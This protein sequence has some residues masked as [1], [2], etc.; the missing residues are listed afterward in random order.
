MQFLYF[1]HSS[2][3]PLIPFLSFLGGFQVRKHVAEPLEASPLGVSEYVRKE[4]EIPKLRVKLLVK[5]VDV[6]IYMIGFRD[7]CGPNL[8]YL[9]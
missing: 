4:I 7:A 6:R 1:S 3:F 8:T 5:V 2:V 9:T